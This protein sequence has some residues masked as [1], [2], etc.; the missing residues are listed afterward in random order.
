MKET[1][2]S[3]GTRRG[4]PTNSISLRSAKSLNRGPCGAFPTH[5]HLHSR[6]STQFHNS[7][8]RRSLVA[9]L[10]DERR[11]YSYGRLLRSR[12]TRKFLQLVDLRKVVSPPESPPERTGFTPNRLG[13]SRCGNEFSL[14]NIATASV[15]PLEGGDR[16]GKVSSP[17]DARRDGAPDNRS[18]SGEGQWNL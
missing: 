12:T 6:N 2:R 4:E 8:L 7:A 16:E 3:R 11:H 5:S 17:G 9:S 13:S 15:G 18:S 1:W 10:R 14:V